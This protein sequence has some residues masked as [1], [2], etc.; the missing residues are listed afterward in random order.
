MLALSCISCNSS[1]KYGNGQRLIQQRQLN[2]YSIVPT[3]GTPFYAF[4]VFTSSSWVDS[5][6]SIPFEH[7]LATSPSELPHDPW[8]NLAIF[9]CNIHGVKSLSLL[10]YFSEPQDNFSP[11]KLSGH[12][13]ALCSRDLHSLLHCSAHERNRTTIRTIT[14]LSIQVHFVGPRVPSYPIF[15]IVT[16]F[17]TIRG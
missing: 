5:G 16:T 2:H 12:K 13:T 14:H 15:T 8:R 11:P 4:S 10:N 1:I 9:T 7:Y 17:T 6:N 3:S